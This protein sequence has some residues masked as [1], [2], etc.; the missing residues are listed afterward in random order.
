MNKLSRYLLLSLICVLWTVSASAQQHQP[1]Q[2]TLDKSIELAQDRS[3]VAKAYRYSLI[4]SRWNYESFR[5]DLY[6]SLSL[7]GDA[8][9]YNKSIFSNILD[10]G[11]TVFS[12]RTQSEASA[13]VSI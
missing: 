10:N 9:G 8:P 1:V 3:P 6:P 12:S 7:N 11:Q 13:Q 2:L 5:A 4:A